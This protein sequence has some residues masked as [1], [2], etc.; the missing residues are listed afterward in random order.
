M[1]VTVQLIVAAACL[2]TGVFCGYLLAQVRSMRRI[3][4]LQ[5][6]LEAARVRLETIAREEAARIAVLEESEGRLRETF[7]ALAGKT[8]QANSELFLRMARETLGRDQVAA[9]S[10]LK[11]R[12]T[13]I[14]QLLE[15][16]RTALERTEAQ[17]QAMERERR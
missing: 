6:E 10:S 3:S 13:A 16:L 9:Q 7:E 1:T 17:V 11:E 12:E 4:Q 2:L 15:P 14:A 5:V 8:L